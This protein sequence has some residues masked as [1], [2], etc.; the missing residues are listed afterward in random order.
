[1]A[2]YRFESYCCY[3]R[4]GICIRVSLPA[5]HEY[6]KPRTFYY[7]WV[8]R[9]SLINSRFWE[10]IGFGWI[11]GTIGNG[12]R[13]SS[14]TTYVGPNYI[15]RPNLHVLLHAHATKLIEVTSL[16]TTIPTFSGVEFGT[17]PSSK[18]MTPQSHVS[19]RSQS[20]RSKMASYCPQRGHPERGSVQHS[21]AS[22]AL[23]NRRSG[24]AGE[25]WHP[26]SCQPPLSRQEHD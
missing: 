23:R 5:G 17:G 11:Q 14:A 3:H 4:T 16:G 24:G 22:H 20:A 13:S 26:H 1:M 12:Q 18:S 7:G 15:N 6:R 19:F 25:T 21:A 2:S 8:A 9:T 10:Q